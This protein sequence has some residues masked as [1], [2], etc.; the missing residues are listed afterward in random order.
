MAR[1]FF[2]LE[3]KNDMIGSI[4]LVLPCIV[5]YLELGVLKARRCVIDSKFD[6]SKILLVVLLGERALPR[7][8]FS[9]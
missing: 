2:R 4:A 3:K 6:E 5:S 8:V 7:S 9:A 1:S